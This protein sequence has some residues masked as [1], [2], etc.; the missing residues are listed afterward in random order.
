MTTQTHKIPADMFDRL[1]E[2]RP[3]PDAIYALANA[4]ISRRLL[5]IK[6]V[7]QAWPAG[8]VARGVIDTLVEA[9]KRDPAVVTGLLAEPHTGAWATQTARRIRGSKGFEQPLDAE[10]AYLG[11][12][13]AAAAARTGVE[14]ELT[15]HSRRGLAAIPSLGAARLPVPDHAAVQVTVVDGGLRILGPGLNVEVPDDPDTNT[16]GWLPLRRLSA[17]ADGHR[18]TVA[19]DDVDPFRDSYHI[20]AADRLSESEARRWN[21][22]LEGAWRLLVSRA[23]G[24]A[25]E[26]RAGLRTMVPLAAGSGP[27]RSAT[28]RDAFGSFGLTAPNSSVEL[29]IAMVHEFQHSKLSALLDLVR[30]HEPS[31][32]AVYYAPWRTDP[33]P[34]GGLFQGVYAFLAIADLWRALRED[35]Q[36]RTDAERG[37]ATTREQVRAGLA[38]LVRSGKLTPAGERFAGGM[39]TRLDALYA[40]PVPAAAEAEARE[41]LRRGYEKW[42]LRNRNSVAS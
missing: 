33:R 26:L 2:G 9:Q 13:A 23:P 17:Q 40:I 29:A 34:L 19:L 20:A 28:V 22:L 3:D 36:L 5:L 39:R 14:V 30:L 21:E 11:A 6:Y 1:A 18:L 25:G 38:E 35:P 10:S 32:P 31:G 7:L 27:A 12:L 41:A 4:Q 37:L 42:L 8:S 15:V 24:H 16:P